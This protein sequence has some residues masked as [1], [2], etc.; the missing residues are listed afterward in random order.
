MTHP[1][2]I[3]LAARLAAKHP[4][5]NFSI[6][7]DPE[8]GQPRGSLRT[9][10]LAWSQVAAHATHHLVVQDDVLLHPDFDLV[11]ETAVGAMPDRAIAFFSEWGSQTSYAIRLGALAG[12]GW[13]EAVDWYVPSL[14][15]VLP[16]DA[17][18][19]FDNFAGNHRFRSR[20]ED[21][22]LL[23]E[24]LRLL[25]I[26]AVIPVPNWAEHADGPSVA[27]NDSHGLRK[28]TVFLPEV[29]IAKNLEI[30]WAPKFIPSFSWVGGFPYAIRK[31]GNP[32]DR[33][34]RVPIEELLLEHGLDSARTDEI[35]R[36]AGRPPP[37]EPDGPGR[38][39]RRIDSM[40]LCAIALGASAAYLDVDI[41]AALRSQVAQ[42][43]LATM[44]PGGLKRHLPAGTLSAVAH[45]LS[46]V[47]PRCIALGYL[48]SRSPELTFTSLATCGRRSAASRSNS[49]LRT[50]AMKASTRRDQG[51]RFQAGVR[52]GELAL[53]H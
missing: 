13:V 34:S 24:F 35:L 2:R 30:L 49:P 47:I 16:A 5:L 15:L 10:R 17:A 43:A 36:E 12:A 38:D 6:V 21:D 37:N 4:A 50:P 7:C 18:R 51:S 40:A 44:V 28:A 20:I 42:G 22:D 52:A 31:P 14:A 32:H 41:H 11:L 3:E 29:G 48:S 26:Q 1:A 45:S 27:G 25:G 33:W 53:T 8:P 23:Y 46:A 19:E 9:S 39:A